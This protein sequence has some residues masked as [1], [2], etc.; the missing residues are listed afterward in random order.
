MTETVTT[1]AEARSEEGSLVE[2]EAYTGVVADHTGDYEAG[3][4]VF[5]ANTEDFLSFLASRMHKSE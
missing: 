2:I 4:T 5:H 3:R 1:P